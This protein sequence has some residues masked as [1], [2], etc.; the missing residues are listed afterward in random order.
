M[1]GFNNVEN[2][3]SFLN[4][5]EA[6][7]NS[8]A[9]RNQ[10]LADI[11]SFCRFVLQDNPQYM[12]SLQQILNLKFKKYK[13]S[14]LVYLSFNQLGWLL[15]ELD[16]TNRYGFKDLVILT[17]L[18]DTG[19]HVSEFINCTPSRLFKNQLTNNKIYVIIFL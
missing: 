16:Y 18:Y 6:S 9:T 12:Y 5:L 13:T 19:V 8:I 1:V 2:I 3:K 17:I 4:F 7:G 15:K 10:R 11:K 14:A